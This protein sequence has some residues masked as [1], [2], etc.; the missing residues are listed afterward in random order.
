MNENI[1]DYEL[2]DIEGEILNPAYND[3]NTYLIFTL[4]LKRL[5]DLH[6]L[7]LIR[8]DKKNGERIMDIIRNLEDEAENLTEEGQRFDISTFHRN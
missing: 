6:L 3:E 1:F 5:S 7:F 4:N 2:T 8:R